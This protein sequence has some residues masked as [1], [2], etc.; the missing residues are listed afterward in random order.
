[1]QRRFI[2]VLG[3]IALVLVLVVVPNSGAATSSSEIGIGG[4]V[5]G[6]KGLP[7]AEVEAA[8]LP[9]LDPVQMVKLSDSGAPPK[10]AARVLTNAH[11]SFHLMAPRAGLWKVRLQA[12]GFV[13]LEFPLE[14]LIEPVDLPDAEMLPDFGLTVQVTG[15]SGQPLA[16]A[17]VRLASPGQRGPR[18]VSWQPPVRMALTDASGAAVLL[19]SEKEP[20]VLTVSAPGHVLQERRNVRGTAAVFKLQPGSERH[21]AVVSSDRTPAPSVLVLSADSS[22]P[23]GFTDLQGR[24]SVTLAKGGEMPIRVMAEDG[25]RTQGTLSDRATDAGAATSPDPR[26]AGGSGSTGS[27]PGASALKGT[28]PGSAASAAP[29]GAASL[30]RVFTLPER[31]SIKGRLI[32]ARTRRAVAGGLVWTEDEMWAASASDTAGGYTLHGPSGRNVE[33][34]AGAAGYLKAD[35]ITFTLT[36]DGRPAPTLALEPAAVIEGVVLDAGGR[37]VAGAEASLAIQRSGDRVMIILGREPEAPR[38]VTSA[39]GVFR[40]SPVDPSNNYTL[41]VTAKGFAPSTKEILGLEPLKTMSGLRIELSQGQTVTGRVVDAEGRPIRDADAA[42]RPPA[43]A[44]RPGGGM[45]GMELSMGGPAPESKASTDGDGRFRLAGLGTGTFDLEVRRTG[46]ARKTVPTVEVTKRPEP[47]DLGDLVMEPG[48]R[49]QGLV[50]APD[51]TPIEGVEVS[52]ASASPGPT[53]MLRRSSGQPPAAVTGPDGRFA[54]EDLRGDEPLGLTFSRTSYLQK[55]EN[56]IQLPREEPLQI[57]MQP[58]SKVSGLVLGPDKKPIPGAQVSLTRSQ[59]GG[60]GNEM[61]KMIMRDGTTAADDGRFVFDDVSPGSIS[62]STV[63]S[64]WREAKIDGI[65]V[66]QGKDV[67]GVEIPLKPG[68]SVTGRVLSPDGRPVIGARVGLVSDDPEPLRMDGGA[69]SDGDGV[70][71]LEGMAPGRFSLEATHDDY[72][73][74]AKEIEARAGSNK[75]DLQ[76][77]GGQD[78]S[79][80]VT[81]SSGTPIGGAWVQLSSAGRDW[82]GPDTTTRPDGTFKL[83]GVGDGDYTIGAAREGYASSPGALDVHVEGKPVA[84]LKIQLDAG[85]RITGTVSGVDPSKL[86]QVDVRASSAAGNASGSVDREGRY[87]LEHLLP[88][89]WTVSASIAATGQQTRGQVLVEQG[90]AEAALDL[91]F[92]QGL[93]LSGRAVRGEAPVVGAVLFAQGTNVNHSSWGRTGVE[94]SFRMEGLE[95]GTYRVE[96]RHWETGLSY[97]ETIEVTSSREVTLRIPIA[98]VVGRIVDGTDRRPV[99]GATV[100]LARSGQDGRGSPVQQ[101]GATSDLNGRFEIGS[102]TDGTWIVTASKTG[103]AA[104]TA[105]VSVQGSHDVDDVRVVLDATEGL[106]LEA[107]LPSGRVPETVDVAVLDAVGRSLIAGSYATG[108]NGRVRL[109]SVPPGSWDLVVSA[110]GAGVMNL[111]VT[112]PGPTVSAPLPQACHLKVTVPALA[113]STTAA[114]ATIKGADERVFRTLGWMSDAM[115]QWRLSGG[116]IELDTLPPGSWTIQV[117]AADG[118]TWSGTSSTRPGTPAEVLLQ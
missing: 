63:A 107:R 74:A 111:R 30:V 69:T 83:E 37:P 23:L 17:R 1:M 110:A 47:I 93:T 40:L 80:L 3:L 109:S 82:G 21:L 58:A 54:V 73:R 4:R 92:G 102:V 26:P 57:T 104:S 11:G 45:G 19:R 76:F 48:L 65:E 55:R 24:L 67:E 86:T 68:A 75:L 90:A 103:Y 88:G 66:A 18:S 53:F 25:R 72:V 105:E 2:Q 28:G 51:G 96:L 42:L 100:S 95:P 31:L 20:F 64:S 33:M 115:S 44:R 98:R 9:A 7:L 81:D 50:T 14:P 99:A 12:S 85:A 71:R 84:G 6:P 22:H 97:D 79:G 5:L 52:V 59:S 46:F 62:L 32:D 106:A 38:A 34:L 35:P 116:R 56:G 117:A 36:V 27:T 49:V 94:G 108:E 78:V 60:I 70:Y 113:G 77:E 112:V 15:R 13:P 16:R 29:G 39:Q 118:R 91:Q 61:F 101:R 114:T 87:A 89:T 43:R 10:P 41:K 8:L